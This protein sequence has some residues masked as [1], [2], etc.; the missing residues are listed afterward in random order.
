MH[1]KTKII[2]DC[3]P[4]HDDAIAIL[5]A[6][7]DPLA[8]LLAVTTVAGNQTVDKTSYNAL[9]VLTLA[10]RR[11]IPVAAGCDRP[12][13][14]ELVTAPKIHGMSGLDG[15]SLP[16]PA[17]ALDARHAVELITEV[18]FASDQPVTLVPT[19]PLTNIAMALRREP[20]LKTHISRI[21]WMGGSA[22]EGNTTPSAE[23][24]AYVDPEAAEMVFRSGIPITMV[25]LDV[26]H[27][28][29]F[30]EENAR[31]VRA[32]GSPVTAAV[33]DLLDFFRGT[34][35]AEFGFR[36]CPL[37]DPCAV[38]EA[39][40]PGMVASAPMRVEI[41]TEGRWTRGRTVC[42]RRGVWKKEPNAD[43]GIHLHVDAFKE[44]VLNGLSRYAP[45]RNLE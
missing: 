20:Q 23:F 42:D 24:N 25:G 18:A 45:S 32:L 27:Q 36:G 43:V 16:E 33:A 31:A 41:E 39:L 21:V 3:D 1:V 12:L 29:L 17:F 13:Y 7:A 19:A 26:T 11:D 15:A 22:G 30:T 2:L 44:Y 10:G 40:H 9:R 5:L 37:H 28:A 6:A 34:Y 4:G 35:L 8:E 38:A 14:R